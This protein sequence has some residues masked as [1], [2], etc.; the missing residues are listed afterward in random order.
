MGQDSFPV[1]RLRVANYMIVLPYKEGSSSTDPLQRAGDAAERQM[2]HY[3]HR[4]FNDDPSVCVLHGLRIE[5]WI[6][7]N[8]AADAC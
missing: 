1:A 8:V 7:T 6:A 5:T 3:L 4:T 2:A